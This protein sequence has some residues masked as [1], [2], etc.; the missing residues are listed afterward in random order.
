MSLETIGGPMFSG[1]SEELIRRLKRAKIAGM[2]ILALKPMGD[3]RWRSTEIGTHHGDYSFQAKNAT[4]VGD[5]LKLVR[6]EVPDVLAIDEVPLLANLKDEGAEKR[7]RLG[8]DI[9][10]VNI[11]DA[12]SYLA[13]TSGIRVIVTGL[14]TYFNGMPF[15]IMDDLIARAG[16]GAISLDAICAECGKKAN[17]TQRFRDCVHV[18]VIDKS[19]GDVELT[20]SN[21]SETYGLSLRRDEKNQITASDGSSITYVE[22]VGD[23]IYLKVDSGSSSYGEKGLRAVG[24]RTRKFDFELIDGK[25]EFYFGGVPANFN[26]PKL[27]LGGM[28][29]YEAR[30]TDCFEVPGSPVGLIGKI[31][32]NED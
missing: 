17:W 1:K 27:V 20:L 9:N 30:C 7:L 32:T 16:T 31:F 4:C 2:R 22:R 18:D 19:E 21:S 14:N 10:G 23:R 12:V 26:D 13:F 24:M 11:A 8:V 15:D 5:V 6:E 3:E 25:A 28:G 29:M